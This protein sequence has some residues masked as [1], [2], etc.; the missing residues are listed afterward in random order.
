MHS[1]KL[2][3]AQ[4]MEHLPLHTFRRCVARYPSRYP[5]LRFSHLDQFLCMAF[6]QLTFRESLR[7]IETCLRAQSSKLYHL[8][9]RGGVARSTLADANET[10]DWRIYQD[11]AV[12]LIRIARKL[13]ADDSFAVELDN[14]AYA[15]D[16]T[17]IEMSMSLFPWAH[18]GGTHAAVKLHTL[19][20]LRGNIP[21]FLYISGAKTGELTVFDQL[22]FEPGSFYILDRGFTDYSR[23][24]R[25][26][27]ERAY[28]VIR[29]RSNMQF[30]RL[31]SHHVDKSSGLRCDQTI[32]LGGRYSAR[33]YPQPLRRVKYFDVE[34]DRRLVFLTNHSLLPALSIAQLY[35]CRWQIE[36]F[37]KWIK[38]H[39]RIKAFFGRSENAVKTQI[40]IAVAVYVLVAIV[41][42]RLNTSASLYTVLQILSLTLF[43]K[44]PLGQLLAEIESRPETV[45][46]RNQLNLFSDISGQ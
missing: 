46:T 39:L 38:Q 20:D 40:W 3:F 36:L 1:G 13:Y 24:Y 37:F 25:L 31:Q 21:S 30:L 41:K 35:R 4:L 14:T 19:L 22:I 32:M 27:Q 23:L 17:T 34:H 5:T 15:L 11:F 26:H 7:D 42:K 6:A 45:E 29:A 12:N 9:I 10:R 8:G 16:T 18:Y 2:V 44:Q 28:F 33:A 43:D